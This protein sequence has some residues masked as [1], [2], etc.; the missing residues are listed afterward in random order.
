MS[1]HVLITGATGNLGQAVLEKFLKKKYQ[2]SVAVQ[3]G[4]SFKD[5]E[6]CRG[7]KVDL[8]DPDAAEKFVRTALLTHRTID[9]AILLVGGFAMGSIHD[10]D[11]QALDKMINLNFKTAYNTIKPVFKQKKASPLQLTYLIIYHQ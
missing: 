5:S 3:P 8:M 10:T 9:I 4:E 1:G 6:K 7:F 11:E 2:I